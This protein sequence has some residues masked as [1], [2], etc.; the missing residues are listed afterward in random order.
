[1]TI[2]AGMAFQAEVSDGPVEGKTEWKVV[3]GRFASWGELLTKTTMTATNFP[4][5][6]EPKNAKYYKIV[7]QAM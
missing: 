2:P 4:P 1:M 5:T 3:A 7:F 6:L